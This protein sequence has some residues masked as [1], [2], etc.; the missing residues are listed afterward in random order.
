[1]DLK[2]I[3]I[4]IILL[5]A[6]MFLYYELSKIRSDTKEN[7]LNTKLFIEKN[8]S[9]L[10]KQI[11]T[12]MDSSTEKIKMINAE[13]IQQVRK[14][15]IIQ[16][17]PIKIKKTSNYYTENDS[18]CEFGQAIKYLSES[19]LDAKKNIA[20]GNHNESN[21]Y[22]SQDDKISKTSDFKVLKNKK[23][24]TDSSTEQCDQFNKD[25]YISSENNFQNSQD[26]IFFVVNQKHVF[27]TDKCESMLFKNYDVGS[28]KNKLYID[29]IK[30]NTG[31]LINDDEYDDDIN[32]IKTKISNNIKEDDNDNCSFGDE[33]I[34]IY[35]ENSLDKEN[36]QSNKNYISDNNKEIIEIDTKELLK[37]I[38][39]VQ[40]LNENKS[41]NQ[42]IDVD[43]LNKSNISSDIEDV[44]EYIDEESSIQTNELG[45][46]NKKTFKNINNYKMDALKKIAKFYKVPLSIKENGKYRAYNKNE[47]YSKI[48]KALNSK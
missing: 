36:S 28:A 6:F 27:P 30:K 24:S 48:K 29:A 33:S 1:M 41:N 44:E 13:N 40:K 15:N 38:S 4:V 23:N 46:I 32:N 16:N 45:D 17:E 2:I 20:N 47:L 34:E 10:K 12:M 22:M 8:N 9:Q 42:E 7:S 19:T 35:S 37:E 5:G 18:D 25:N 3:I 43:N 39:D 14:M 21:P 26:H 11:Q 31:V